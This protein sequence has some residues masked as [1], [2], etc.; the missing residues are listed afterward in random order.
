MKKLSL[1]KRW[2]A[3]G[4]VC[5]AA[6]SPLAGCG[7]IDGQLRRGPNGEPSAL[8]QEVKAAQ[9]VLG[10]WGALASGLVTLAV[11]IYG[12]VHSKGANDNVKALKEDKSA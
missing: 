12:A 4:I 2:V 6:T 3:A 11:G 10:P 9:P 1:L 5:L 8:E 7:F